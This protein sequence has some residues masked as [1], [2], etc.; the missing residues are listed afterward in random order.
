MTAHGVL[1]FAAIR[2]GQTALVLAAAGGVGLILVQL[3][4]HAG[5]RVIGVVSTTEKRQAVA[6]LG[7]EVIVGYEGFD[8]AALFLTNG[9][10]V[11][12]VF[13]SVGRGAEAASFASLAPHGQLIYYGDA[14]GLP[15]AV[16]IESL[17]GRSLRVGAFGLDADRDVEAADI[18]RRELAGALVRGELR[19]SV[20]K[21]YS[22]G[23]AAA[24]HVALEGRKTTG[25]LVLVP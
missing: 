1:Q 21:S 15:S 22:L 14:G 7:A 19:L 17:Y 18:A 8:Q 16:D 10:G 11:D 3:A 23:E 20:S 24:A 6:S 2:P 25:K 5:V 9:R 4:R 13:D 12:V